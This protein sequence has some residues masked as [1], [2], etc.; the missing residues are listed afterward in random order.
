VSESDLSNN[1]VP[2]KLATN[3]EIFEYLKML[4]HDEFLIERDPVTFFDLMRNL[5][6][7][8]CEN[9]LYKRVLDMDDKK[10]AD[11]RAS[12]KG[13]E[14]NAET[15]HK[16]KMMLINIYKGSLDPANKKDCKI[17]PIN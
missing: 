3:D 6:L 14:I 11:I 16:L 4:L 1:A 13:T 2:K 8:Y 17:I 9:P 7:M 12:K 5:V 15:R 10:L